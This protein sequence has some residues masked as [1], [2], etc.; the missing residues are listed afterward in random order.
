MQPG[1]A[2]D[3]GH[4]SRFEYYIN[5]IRTYLSTNTGGQFKRCIGYLMTIELYRVFDVEPSARQLRPERYRA[6][7]WHCPVSTHRVQ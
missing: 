7:A 4:I 6:Q 3:I 5:M 1:K 2:L